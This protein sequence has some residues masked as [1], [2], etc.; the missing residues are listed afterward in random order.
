MAEPKKLFSFEFVTLIFISFFAFCNMA[1]FYSFFDYLAG[2]GIPVEWRGFL[3]GLEPMSAFAMR[4]AV[5]PLLHL[6]NAVR[7]MT[8]ALTM[9]VVALWSYSWAV[10]VPSLI[11]LRIFHGA[12]FVLLVS[13]SMS[14]VVHLIP[15]ERSAQGFGIVSVSVLVP[16]AVM[17]LLTDS[18]LRYVENEAGI[19]AGVTAMAV[20]GLLLLEVLRRRLKKSMAGMG[21]SLTARPGLD[22][23]KQNIRQPTVVIILGVTLL[24]YLSYSTV[25]FFMKSFA[26][27]AELGSSGVFFT[28]ST[29]VIMGV[30]VLS[31]KFLDKINKVRGLQIFAVQLVM[32]FISFGFVRSEWMYRLLAGYYGLCIG[33]FVPLLNS[34]MFLASPPRLRGLNTNLSLFMMDAGFFLGPCLGGMLVAAGCSF[35]LLF[36]VCAGFLAIGLALLTVLDRRTVSDARYGRGEAV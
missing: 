14:L 19:Y 24:L 5:I 32:C 17:P 28:I 1:V 15:A 13:A 2:I 33:V 8:L 36:N 7:V 26:A 25:F 20:P 18:L 29:L 31:G 34:A 27:R 9:L 11:V 22:D 6:G 16:Y 35:G 12:A 4:L 30:R 23:L 21:G 10:T 3:L